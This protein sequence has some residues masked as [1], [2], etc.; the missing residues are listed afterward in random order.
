[1]LIGQRT[2]G[3]G[4]VQTTRPLAYNSQLKVTTAKYYIP[5]GR[6]IQ[7][8][9][10]THRKDD[11][12]VERFADSLKN[13]FKTKGGRKVFDGGGLDPD[14]TVE[15]EYVGTLTSAL[16]NK[17]LV[18]EFA[19]KYCAQNPVKPDLKSFRLSDKDFENF[20]SYAK[21]QK[22]SYTTAL[23]DDIS[24][25]V[26]AAKKEPY[27]DQLSGELKELE[28]KIQASKSSDLTN[29]KSEIMTILQEQIGFHY[30]L[31]EG[32]AAVTLGQDKA[33]LEARKV[34]ND[35]LRYNKL[36]SAN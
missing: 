25:L 11:G 19:S 16:I 33:L 36:L 8:L 14:I 17:G 6:C 18:F 23:E 9:D 10:Y 15:D 2:F 28:N 20:L 13:E 27:Y 29:Y 22:F 32:Q 35:S 24:K 4:L 12:T 31:Y 26:D 3:K 21:S 5:S 34:L 30:D 7:A 1:V